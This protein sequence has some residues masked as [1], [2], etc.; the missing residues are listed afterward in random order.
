L[1]PVSVELIDEEDP[2]DSARVVVE[3]RQYID[4][5]VERWC[6]VYAIDVGTQFT[7]AGYRRLAA[8]LMNAADGRDR[9]AQPDVPPIV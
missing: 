9:Y 2:Q 8:F 7:A 1:S 5:R 4:G 3:G 6:A